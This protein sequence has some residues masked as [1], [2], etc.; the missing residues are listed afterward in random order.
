MSR[1]TRPIVSIKQEVFKFLL[2]QYKL[3]FK[4]FA[5]KL[6]VSR[7]HLYTCYHGNVSVSPKVQRRILYHLRLAKFDDIFYWNL[8]RTI[9]ENASVKI[10][11]ITS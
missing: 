7:Q 9:Q 3:T 4:T 1:A 5:K 6:K 11:K 2:N 10:N 8:R